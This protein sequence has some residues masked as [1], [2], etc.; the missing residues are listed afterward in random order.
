MFL[1]ASISAL[2]RSA[3]DIV[4]DIVRTTHNYASLSLILLIFSSSSLAVEFPAIELIVGCWEKLTPEP[5]DLPR[6]I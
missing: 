1:L 3:T 4:E 6:V 5:V 2:R